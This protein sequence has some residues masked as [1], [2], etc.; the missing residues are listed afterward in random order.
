[1]REFLLKLV[2]DRALP[3]A[4]P[5]EDFFSA[6]PPPKARVRPDMGQDR[7]AAFA[8]SGR[9]RTAALRKHA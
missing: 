5:H 3:P 7:V 9:R 2:L 6:G 1:M 8:T 4:C